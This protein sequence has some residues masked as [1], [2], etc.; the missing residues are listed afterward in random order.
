VSACSR[1]HLEVNANLTKITLRSI[2]HMTRNELTIHS[3]VRDPKKGVDTPAGHPDAPRMLIV[4]I[5]KVAVRQRPAYRNFYNFSRVSCWGVR[6]SC[7]GV[8]TFFW[9]SNKAMNGQIVPCH[10]RYW[11]QCDFSK[12][13]VHFWVAPNTGTLEHIKFVG[14]LFWYKSGPTQKFGGEFDL[15]FV[16]CR[17]EEEW[18]ALMMVSTCGAWLC[19]SQQSHSH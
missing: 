14:R 15:Q 12:V 8:D 13:H 3:L 10:M 6:V 19:V 17:S 16:A 4:K 18:L 11:P 1:G 9:G 5:I 2:S 7:W